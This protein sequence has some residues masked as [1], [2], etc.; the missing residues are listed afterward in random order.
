VHLWHPALSKTLV[1]ELLRRCRRRKRHFLLIADRR[2]TRPGALLHNPVDFVP[3]VAIIAAAAAAVPAG[4]TTQALTADSTVQNGILRPKKRVNSAA[5]PCGAL[6]C[7]GPTP[8]APSR[9]LHWD[10]RLKRMVDRL[11]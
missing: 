4:V 9:R 3:F 1:A 11:P 10:K 8:M 6:S 2:R 5:N 7:S